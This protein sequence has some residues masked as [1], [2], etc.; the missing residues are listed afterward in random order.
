M[1]SKM[2]IIWIS[3]CFFGCIHDPQSKQSKYFAFRFVVRKKRDYVGKIPKWRTPSP[4]PPS[5]GIFAFFYRFFKIFF[6]HFISP[7]IG[8]NKKNMEWVW[9]RPLP[10]LWEFSPHNPV[11]FWQRQHLLEIYTI[12]AHHRIRWGVSASEVNTWAQLRESSI[13]WKTGK[14]HA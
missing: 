9:V 13:S 7:W 8:K 3:N 11:F 10:P 5:L 4:S 12:D 6:C 2:P 14:I 1:F